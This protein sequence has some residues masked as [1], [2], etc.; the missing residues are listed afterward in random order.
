MLI[1]KLC[2]RRETGQGISSFPH[3][4]SRSS[5]PMCSMIPA[6]TESMEFRTVD[7]AHNNHRLV[8]VARLTVARNVLFARVVVAL[9]TLLIPPD[10]EHNNIERYTAKCLFSQCFR[11]FSTRRTMS[12]V[13]GTCCI[14]HVHCA[15]HRI[16]V[17]AR[18][19]VL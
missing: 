13:Q 12:A 10:G 17:N 7:A 8:D 18:V 9:I 14:R 3:K 5:M 2:H 6:V 1:G 19:S 4:A 16:V 11:L 15:S